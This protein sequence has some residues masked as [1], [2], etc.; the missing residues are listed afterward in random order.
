MP[1]HLLG[2]KSWNVYNPAN[3]AQVRR[4]EAAAAE[5]EAADE[6]RMQEVDAARRTAI[7]RGETPPPIP[8][9][10]A[11]TTT[12]AKPPP[13]WDAQQRRA[14]R[15]LKN[16]DDTDRDIRLA[17]ADYDAGR[18]AQDRLKSRTVEKTEEAELPLTDTRGHIQLFHA[19]AD[20]QARHEHA[21]KKRKVEDEGKGMQF[22]DAAGYRTAI[23]GKAWYDPSVQDGGKVRKDA[24]G[25]EDARRQGRDE[26]RMA[27]DDPMAAM[28]RA[29]G[30]LKAV[31]KERAERE[32]RKDFEDRRRRRE[33]ERRRDDHKDEESLDG[34]SLDAGPEDMRTEEEKQR[35]RDHHGRRGR[36]ERRSR[37][38]RRT[39]HERSYDRLR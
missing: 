33:K 10:D 23:G 34:F 1:L 5:R 8:D 7:L 38:P 30:Q 18:A 14:R 17:R 26:R 4:D 35:R 19:P 32:G 20:T 29:Q 3:I 25:R 37:S 27:S 9:D 39:R 6:Q 2:K 28:R 16:E 12:H 13:S 21:D 36:H 11:L 22:A 31:A 24:F 15:R